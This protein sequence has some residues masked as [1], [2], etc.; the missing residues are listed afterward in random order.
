MN[1]YNDI[2]L[3]CLDD[4][5]KLLLQFYVIHIHERSNLTTK[6]IFNDYKGASRAE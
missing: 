5:L 1:V 2:V 3:Y 4:I 6:H